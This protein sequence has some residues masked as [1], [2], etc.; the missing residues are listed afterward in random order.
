[1]GAKGFLIAGEETMPAQEISFKHIFIQFNGRAM[2]SR[3]LIGDLVERE[4]EPV[5]SLR[6]M[7]QM[8][9]TE[10]EVLAA[11]RHCLVGS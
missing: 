2:F 3:N 9:M 6:L 5:T 11:D 10:Q 4:Q 1:M 8:I 7:A